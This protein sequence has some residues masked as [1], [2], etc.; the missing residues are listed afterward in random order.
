[1]LPALWLSFL[2]NPEQDPTDGKNVTWPKYNS[3]A[4]TMLEFAADNTWAQL[5]DGSIVDNQC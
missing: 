1:M 4:S 3:S 5:V 2:A